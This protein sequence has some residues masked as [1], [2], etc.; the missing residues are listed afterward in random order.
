MGGHPRG[1][2]MRGPPPHRMRG[3]GR[4]RGSRRKFKREL[5]WCNWTMFVF[6][7]EG[8]FLCTRDF[9]NKLCGPVM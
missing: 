4:G 7:F 3:R 9:L 8:N 1:P 5:V 2:P 6:Y